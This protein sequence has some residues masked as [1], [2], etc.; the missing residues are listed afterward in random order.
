MNTETGQLLA[1]K[2][3]SLRGDVQ[4]QSQVSALQSE[5][6]LMQSLNH[7]NIVRYL[8]S[9]K[10]EKKLNIFLEYQPGGSIASL[11]TKFHRL[12]E[13]IIRSFTRQMLLGLEY[14]HQH[15]IAHRDIK[16]ANILVDIDGVIKL[17]DFGA[18]K[19]LASILSYS[20]GFKSFTG[21]PY[22]MAPEVIQ[23]NADGGSY[24]RKADIWSLGAVVIEMATGKPPWSDLAPVTAL[25]K[26][27]S[28]PA[29]PPFPETL[30]LDANDFLSKCFQRDPRLRPSATDLLKHP[31]VSE[32]PDQKIDI[33]QANSQDGDKRTLS[34][35]FEEDETT[36]TDSKSKPKQKSR[37]KKKKKQIKN[38][39][40]VN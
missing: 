12:G 24:G 8:G 20:E 36:S 15:G 6:E 40:S 29:I 19:K 34:F 4:E 18:S 33:L 13:K 23:G 32:I 39:S 31:F 2:Q 11:L 35:S 30:G 14:L 38:K 25:F 16:G 7:K 26:V 37:S 1:V 22:W 17:A 21:T 9:E 3:V 5:I 27:G 10:V 28:S